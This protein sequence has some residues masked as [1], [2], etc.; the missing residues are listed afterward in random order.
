AGSAENDT[1]PVM[2]DEVNAEQPWAPGIQLLHGRMFTGQEVVRA[3]RVPAVNQVFVKRHNPDRDP[4]GRL[5]RLP[6]LQERPFRLPDPSFQ[7]VGVV[8]D[9]INAGDQG[10]PEVYLPY[11]VT[12]RADYLI[13]LAQGDPSAVARAVR[14]QVYTLDPNQPVTN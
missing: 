11:T 9:V 4:I 13:V 1:R 7:I 6:R 5:L 3:A 12:G 8:K 14:A 2:M 10:E